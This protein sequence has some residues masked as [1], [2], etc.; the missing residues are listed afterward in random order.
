MP[1]KEKIQSKEAIIGIIG[2]GYV[3][4]SLAVDIAKFGYCVL[5]VD[6]DSMRVEKI[7][8]CQS[9]ISCV[10]EAE[11]C[12]VVSDG[13]L[14]VYTEYSHL[15]S[16]D[17]IVICV[18]TPLTKNKQPDITSIE[19]AAEQISLHLKQDTMVIL[20][21][22]TYPGT[23]VD[24][25]KPL[26]EKN[27]LK[28]G[29]DFFLAF[30]PERVDPGNMEYNANNTPRVVG[31]IT[32]ECTNLAFDFY[33]QIFNCSVHRVSTPQVAEMSKLLENTYRNV[34]IG[35]INEIA[36]L[37]HNMGIDIWD[38]IDAAKTK[39]FGFQAFYPGPGI[40]GH[41][42]PLDPYY[43]SWKIREYD[44]HATIIEA[45]GSILENMP[46]YVMQRV[47]ELTNKKKILIN[48]AKILILG[49]A[50]KGN[51]NDYRE[52]PSLRLI[53]LLLNY[54]A[55]VEYYDPFIDNFTHRHKKFERINIKTQQLGE[56]NLIIIMTD[57]TGV[58]YDFIINNASLIFDTR[59]VLKKSDEKIIRL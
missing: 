15:S 2:M 17:V 11:L 47:L 42:I 1:L 40:G 38:V 34:N 24:I 36:I 50:Y 58:D 13:N 21:S 32:Q 49:V 35:L 14:K 30:S 39:P 59:N 4:L 3:G 55:V 16:C 33:K 5:G 56:Y 28:C 9:Y 52:S 53:D 19:N 12:T 20:Q 27:G 46:R 25:V 41:C 45:A 23:T 29:K 22:T 7:N 31:G 18:S 10:N 43:F 48:E 8:S 51:V 54:G 57:H 6:G 26:L 44:M 37:C